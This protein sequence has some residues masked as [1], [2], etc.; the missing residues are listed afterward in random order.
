MKC[1]ACNRPL[2]RSAFAVGKMT[3]GPVCF[4]RLVAAGQGARKV[5]LRTADD[6]GELLNQCFFDTQGAADRAALTGVTHA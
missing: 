6:A 1:S 4:K 3:F 2:S 5:D